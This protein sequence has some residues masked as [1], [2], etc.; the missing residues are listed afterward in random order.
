MRKKKLLYASPF[1]PQK[2]GISD[3][4]E[5]LVYALKKY[6]DI[7]ILIDDYKLSENRWY[8][9]FDVIIYGKM[10][11]DFDSYDYKI[12]NIGN[13][14][15]FHSYIYE[16][17][18]KH[19]GLVIMHDF[20]L[21]YLV[22]GYYEG[23]GNVFSKIYEIGGA[24]ALSIIKYAMQ[25]EKK[26]SLLEYKSIASK[27]PLNME[28]LKS[29]NKFMVHSEYTKNR[30]CK[31]INNDLKVRKINHIKLEKSD[32]V[33]LNKHRLFKKFGIPEDALIISSLGYIA[34]TKLNDLV[35]KAVLKLKE[36]YEKKI[37]Y[38]MVGEGDF[39]DK[40]ID[41]YVVFKTGY[42]T[43]DEFNSFLFYS[44]IVANLRYPSMGETSGSMIRVMEYGKPS[45]LIS[46]GW[47]AEIPEDCAVILKTNEFG[48]LEEKIDYL[49]KNDKYRENLGKAAK[50]YVDTYFSAESV[51]AK[52]KDFLEND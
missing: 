49:L 34:E 41:N 50:R 38:V 19:P 52:I 33:I 30:I 26:S 31:C 1:P 12:Y 36:K 43:M 4:S 20:V 39:A 6:Y 18:L 2:S 8:S 5:V 45:I 40:F 13:N 22:T 37:C 7:A 28:L 25:K 42:V 16:I 10:D 15:H 48:E 17:C 46:D 14:P 11:I 47:F 3:Y 51:C 35:C 29:D 21:Y 27:L 24:Q 32:T 44:D 23:L 9:D